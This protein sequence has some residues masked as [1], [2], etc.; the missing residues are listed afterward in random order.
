MFTFTSLKNS[1]CVVIFYLLLI[2]F[3]TSSKVH[4]QSEW[5]QMNSGVT[6]NLC[7]VTWTGKKFIAV[8]DGVILSSSDGKLWNKVNTGLD[9]LNCL[10]NILSFD[11]GN[12]IIAVGYKQVLTSPDGIT[13]TNQTNATSDSLFFSD[14]LWTGNKFVSGGLDGIYTSRDGIKW[15]LCE[16]PENYKS[17]YVRGI[18]WSGDLFIVVDDHYVCTSTDG[19]NWEVCD[20]PWY[21]NTITWT[22]SK[23]IAVTL[24]DQVMST[25]DGKTWSEPIKLPDT[26][27][28]YSS[29]NKK[30]R[31]ASKGKIRWTGKELIYV[32]NA[33]VD[34]PNVYKCYICTSPDGEI[35]TVQYNNRSEALYDITWN[36]SIF[37]A[38]GFNGTILTSL[39]DNVGISQ[40]SIAGNNS[41]NISLRVTGSSLYAS[42]PSVLKSKN[43]S[44][45]MYNISGKKMFKQSFFVADSR[46]ECSIANLASGRYTFV[47]TGGDMQFMKTFCVIY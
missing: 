8:G 4:A 14:I 18:A 41:R 45:A 36:D 11:E 13:W 35:W 42:I 46:I 15:S 44:V 20:E 19:E 39:R 40:K 29:F 27:I 5:T 1:K 10:H 17:P 47:V 43:V 3:L 32:G 31:S 38:V 22:G 21:V 23:F 28:R 26:Y 37:V 9:T 16:T 30:T 25:T 6:K 33:Y 7:A 24:Y 34:T 12:N 2:L